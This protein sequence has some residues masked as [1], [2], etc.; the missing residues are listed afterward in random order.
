M[1]PSWL[2]GSNL[3]RFDVPGL[4]NE[5]WVDK[6]GIACT[7][8]DQLA[9]CV[10]GG[11]AAV[12]SGL[13]WKPH[14]DDWNVSF[15]A[16]WK[17]PDMQESVNKVFTRIPGT[18][19]PST[20]GKLYLPQGYNTI[21]GGLNSA[22]W[23]YIVANDQNDKRNKT[24]GHTTYSF[25]N[26]ERGGPMATYLVTASARKNFAL[27]MNTPVNRVIRTGGHIT[28][29]EVVCG[30]TTGTISVTPNT[31]RVVLSAGTFGSAKLL[32]RSK[33]TAASRPVPRLI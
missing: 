33:K 7:D 31:G 16:G 22:G 4:C 30:S 5:I 10:L 17:D 19:L 2:S 8:Y 14:P 32:W 20:D 9:G 27:W 25:I 6:A 13:Y 28:G 24:Y 26:G 18:T 29:V 3:T 23:T 21:S 1:R 12:N 15:P 11:G